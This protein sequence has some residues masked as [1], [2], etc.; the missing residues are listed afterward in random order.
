[1][2]KGKQSVDVE[3]KIKN[4]SIYTSVFALCPEQESNADAMVSMLTGLAS[5]APA[6]TYTFQ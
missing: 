6:L 4:R 1:V 5:S 2:G 3:G